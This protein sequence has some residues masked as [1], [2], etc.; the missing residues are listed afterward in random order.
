MV[1]SRTKK[2][3][4]SIIG[5]G[6]WGSALAISLSDKFKNIYLIAKDEYEVKELGNKHSALDTAFS[7]NIIISTDI[8]KTTISEAVLI[9]TPSYVFADILEKLK[10]CIS[11]KTY[12]AWATKGFDTKNNCFLFETFAKIMPDYSACVIS[13]PTFAIEI[14]NKNPSAIVVA[15]IDKD[16]KDYWRNRIQT[17]NIRCYSTDDVIGVE[18]GGSVKNVLAIAAG[19]ANG[20]GFGANTQAAIITRGLAEMTR[21]GVALGAKK[22]TLNG[23]SGMGDLVL[24]CSCNLSRNRKFGKELA[25]GNNTQKALNNVG[26][27]VE[28]YNTIELVLD[29]A[30]K[31]GVE[32]PI[33][34]QVYAVIEGEKSPKEAV[35]ELMLRDNNE[36]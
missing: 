4:I 1:Q 12:I 31:I 19:I 30:L 11:G 33:C 7:E 35:I 2:D 36:E 3:S 34:E 8:N 20:L 14:A 5:S 18:I 15:S 25:S 29:K 32:M 28:G 16:V 10:P 17:K 9:A 22:Q 23:L 26:A 24:T 6:A 27:T 13:G 21:L